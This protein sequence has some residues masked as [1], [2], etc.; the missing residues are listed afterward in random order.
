MNKQEWIE[1]FEAINGRKPSINEIGQA[2][3]NGAI[4]VDVASRPSILTK[5][6]YIVLKYK[7][8]LFAII[9]LLLLSIFM[10]FK[11]PQGTFTGLYENDILREGYEVIFQNKDVILRIDGDYSVAEYKGQVS[12]LNKE[13]HFT[14][15]NG[16][17]IPDE[18]IKRKTFVELYH[19]HFKRNLSGSKIELILVPTEET[20][21]SIQADATDEEREINKSENT[22]RISLTKE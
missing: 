22:S 2:I 13:L 5:L 1:A 12:G 8:F 7:Q 4:K 14:E 19:I 20:L 11:V 6:R 17:T 16:I 10:M 3:K 15:Y 9:G 18:K 21:T